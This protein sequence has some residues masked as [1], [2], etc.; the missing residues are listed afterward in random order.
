M[1]INLGDRQALSVLDRQVHALGVYR[2]L[3]EK[4]AREAAQVED[5]LRRTLGEG[6]FDLRTYTAIVTSD[7]IIVTPKEK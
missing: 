2:D 6:I 7:Q 1:T 4:Y 3:A 5:R